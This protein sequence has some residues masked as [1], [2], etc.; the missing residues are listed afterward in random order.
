MSGKEMTTVIRQKISNRILVAAGFPVLGAVA[1]WLLK[2]LANW[3]ASWPWIPWEGPVELVNNAPEP[4]VTLVSLLVGALAGGVLVLMA[5]HG[6][7][8]VTIEDDQVTTDR[9]DSSQSVSRAAIHGVFADGKRLVVLGE[10]GQELAVESKTEGADLPTVKQLA[11]GFQ[12]HGYP[13]LPDGDPY[14]DEYRRWVED[15]PGLPVSGNALLKA[16]AEAL[17]K[18]EESNVAELRQE[19]A[20]LGIVVR[21]TGKRQWW[22]R[23]RQADEQKEHAL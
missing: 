2:L 13:W 14:Q 16:R 15:M 1:G 7:V 4:V 21:D 17:N 6:Y 3:A 5:E 9:G 12:T 23:V 11:N 19:L 10:R 22:R 8:T 18:Q 20:K